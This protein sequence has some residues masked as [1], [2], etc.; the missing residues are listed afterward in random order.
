[1]PSNAKRTTPAELAEKHEVSQRRI[2]RITRSLELG[3]G[4]GKRYQLTPAQ[5][6]QVEAKLKS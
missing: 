1:M 2:R 3:V 4:R 5:V 6:K